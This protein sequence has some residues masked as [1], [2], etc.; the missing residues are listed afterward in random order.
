[1]HFTPEGWPVGGNSTP[2]EARSVVKYNRWSVENPNIC[3]WSPRVDQRPP[4]RT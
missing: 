2:F 4:V 1:M 3:G